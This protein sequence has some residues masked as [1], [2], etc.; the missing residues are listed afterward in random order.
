[1]ES[2]SS[3]MNVIKWFFDNFITGNISFWF[4]QNE[5]GKKVVTW[6]S[7]LQSPQALVFLRW[8]ASGPGRIIVENI[9]KKMGFE[10]ISDE[11][12][13]ALED[14]KIEL[15]RQE[16]AGGSVATPIGMIKTGTAIDKIL[17]LDEDRLD[18]VLNRVFGLPQE[19]IPVAL[20]IISAIQPDSLRHLVDLEDI[21]WLKWGSLFIRPAVPKKTELKSIDWDAIWVLVKSTHLEVM[22]ILKDMHN[23]RVIRNEAALQKL[24]SEW[25][26]FRS[27]WGRLVVYSVIGSLCLVGLAVLIFSR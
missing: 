13:D 24:Q 12:R 21:D 23:K 1:M 3:S 2:G 10:Q 15:G 16:M 8:V 7:G 19:E 4:K 9:V 11:I 27:G 20:S 17:A 14:V 6:I 18:T 22:Y 26:L 25:K 5:M